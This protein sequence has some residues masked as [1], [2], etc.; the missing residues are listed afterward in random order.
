MPIGGWCWPQRQQLHSTG[1]GSSSGSGV[2]RSSLAAVT[3]L[4][5][6]ILSLLGS[7]ALV[8]ARANTSGA[9]SLEAGVTS[10]SAIE[11]VVSLRSASP[12]RSASMTRED[13]ERSI[14]HWAGGAVRERRTLAGA[15]VMVLGYPS[16]G[17]ASAALATLRQHPDVLHAELN[18]ARTLN[19]VPDDQRY[20]DQADWLEQIAAPSGWD[21]TSGSEQVIVAVV[22]SGISPTHPDLAARLVPGVN[23]T[24]D[25]GDTSDVIGH[26]THVA[27]IIAAEGNNAIG[28]V[29]VAMDVRIMPVRVVDVDGQLNVSNV[30]AGI[31]WAV[32]NGADVINLSFGSEQYVQAEHDAVRFAVAQGVIVVAA[33]GNV[34]DQISWPASYDEAISV[35]AL[36]SAGM[37]SDFSSQ[38]SRVDLAAPGE[39]IFTTG[40]ESFY[41]DYWSDID[42]RDL[43]DISGTSF[44]AA[45]VSG[46]AALVRSVWPGASQEMVRSLLVGAAQDSGDP[47]P[48][49]GAGAG[50]LQVDRAL[51][52]ALHH[53][54]NTTWLPSD[55]P[56][57]AGDVVRS[58]LWGA[59]PVQVVAESYDEAVHGV[60]LVFYFDKS[61]MEVTDPLAPRDDGWYV[62]NGLLA[63]E[64]IS[65]QQ[66]VGDTRFEPRPPAQVNVA[67]DLDD[68]DAPVYASFTR[69]LDTPTDLAGDPV[70][71]TL[72]RAGRVNASEHLLE[73]GV[74]S[75]PIIPETWHRVASVFWTYLNSSGPLLKDGALVDGP[76]FDPW[77]YATGLPITEPYWTRAKV[78]G[79][80]QDVLVQCFERRCLTY[81]PSNAAGWQVEMGNV[82]LHYYTWRYGSGASG[83]DGTPATAGDSTR[84]PAGAAP[85]RYSYR[86]AWMFGY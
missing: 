17:D 82:G 56:V 27:G 33:A 42:F 73:Y 63:R 59:R 3:L 12:F 57:A 84:Q 78:D 53:A 48:Q 81:T 40:W 13:V 24:D 70:L 29:G 69:L 1:I 19:W 62:T 30:I 32:D 86:Q 35:G 61:R 31:Y 45:M 41:G 85:R 65:G 60:R 28:T 71:T 5:T 18:A 47:G 22:D 10:A 80:I 4:A 43:Q 26:G 9:R 7:P 25:G 37:P 15:P 52:E 6:L 49:A 77:F 51:R 2:R 76:L 74:T 67:G 34:V 16:A 64:M 14:V 39:R 83:T 68:P 11:V 55:A 44:S 72:D 50:L 58:W 21:I 36:D 66:Q 54:I 46:A 8:A 79:V 20:S 23:I 75:G 38:V